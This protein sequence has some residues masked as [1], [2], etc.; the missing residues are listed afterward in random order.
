M[1]TSTMGLTLVRPSPEVKN[2]RTAG[3]FTKPDAD[4]MVSLLDL[5]LD[6]VLSREVRRVELRE[7]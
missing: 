5:L 4:N 1:L 2:C 3:T 7:Y 6:T